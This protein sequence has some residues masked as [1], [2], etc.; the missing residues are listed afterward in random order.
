[1]QLAFQAFEKDSQLSIRKAARFYNI[2]HSTLSTRINGVS[3]RV[4]TMAN[5]RKLTV[6]E[7]NIVVQEILDLDSRGFPFRM[8]DVKD[9]A[10]RLLTIYDAIY[11]GPRWTSNFVK[12]QPELCTRWNH[13]Y[14]Y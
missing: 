2:L 9:I 8:Y 12:R 4:I 7:E 13:P 6:L 3:I 11:V 10:N 5:L 1:M 14:D